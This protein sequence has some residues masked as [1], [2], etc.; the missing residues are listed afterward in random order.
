MDF[1]GEFDIHVGSVLTDAGPLR[2][3]IA[4][5]NPSSLATRHILVTS[6]AR[7]YSTGITDDRLVGMPINCQRRSPGKGSDTTTFRASK[8]RVASRGVE[9]TGLTDNQRSTAE[10]R[11]REEN[12]ETEPSSW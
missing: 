1:I 10:R 8:Q 5:R 7:S 3:Y 2:L 4:S 9:K 6:N 11:F 12:P